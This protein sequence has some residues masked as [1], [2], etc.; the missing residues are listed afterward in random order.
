MDNKL[1]SW[2]ARKT[3]EDR[4][5]LGKFCVLLKANKDR[6]YSRLQSAILNTKAQDWTYLMSCKP[7]DSLEFD[8][9]F[10]SKVQSTSNCVFYSITNQKQDEI[11]GIASFMRID[12]ANGVCEI[13]NIHFFDK[14]KNSRVGT[15]AIYLMLSYLFD[16]LKYRRCEWKC[17]SK[18]SKSISAAMRLGFS[19][20][21]IFKKSIVYKNRNRDTAWFSILD[22]EWPHLK[23]KFEKW[24]DDDN[25]NGE[26][27]KFKLNEM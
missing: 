22:S 24:L 17:D 6:D 19:L 20:D 16:T 1:E 10:N 26:E 25:F 3:P 21:G 23:S 7:T 27:Q 14:I 2:V 13:G 15:E 18:N 9:W 11:L 4:E 12:S 5:I 8:K